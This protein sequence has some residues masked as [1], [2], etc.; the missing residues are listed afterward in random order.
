MDRTT[1]ATS[2]QKAF[3][4]FMESD[5]VEKAIISSTIASWGGGFYAVELFPDGSYRVSDSNQIGN[6]Y[7]SPGHIFAIPTLSDSDYETEEKNADGETEYVA[8]DLRDW[9]NGQDVYFDNAIDALRV[10]FAQWSDQVD[11]Y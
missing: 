11:A 10:D 9:P 1:E 2:L 4:A 8:I 6:L 7:F 3:E 5:E